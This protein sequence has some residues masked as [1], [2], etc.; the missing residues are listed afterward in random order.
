MKKGIIIL[1]GIILMTSSIKANNIEKNTFTII[2]NYNYNNSV[3]FFENRVEFFIFPNGN[4]DFDMRYN[5][6]NLRIRRDFKGRIRSIGNILV[7]YN[8]RN[9]VSRIGDIRMR[10]HNNRL[11]N[12]GDLRIRYN[13][14]NSP[15]FY[16]QVRNYNYNGIRFNVNIGDI[17]EYNDPY[18]YRNDFNRN[19]IQFREDRNYYYYRSRINSRIGNRGSIIKRKK[20]NSRISNRNVTI[21]SSKEFNNKNK[22]KR[23]NKS[24]RSD[25]DVSKHTF[26]KKRQKSST[27]NRQRRDRS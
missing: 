20:S 21:R 6:R 7:N 15:I 27:K 10:Y 23:S 1:L 26:N 11:I 16:G 8:H 22:L 12:V 3:S 25:N 4:F 19:Y 17:C 9:N 18:F 13:R 2:T 24:V 14:W 5:K